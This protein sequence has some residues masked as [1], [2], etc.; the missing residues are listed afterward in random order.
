MRRSASSCEAVLIGSPMM[1][2]VGVYV[3]MSIVQRV[4]CADA[5]VVAPICEGSGFIFRKC[6]IRQ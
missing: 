1:L 4:V 2:A 6:L 3:G 5:M